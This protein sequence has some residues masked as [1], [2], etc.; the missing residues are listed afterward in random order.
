MK[1]EKGINSLTV[2]LNSKE[3]K[4]SSIFGDRLS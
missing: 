1:P 3:V 4:S 2:V